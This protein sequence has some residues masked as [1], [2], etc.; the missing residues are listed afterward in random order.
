VV[1]CAKSAARHGLGGAPGAAPGCAGWYIHCSK[2]RVQNATVVSSADHK[3]A[4]SADQNTPD[5]LGL[6]R[7]RLCDVSPTLS[8]ILMLVCVLA[9]HCTGRAEENNPQPTVTLSDANST[10]A[11]VTAIAVPTA[12]T[13][14]LSLSFQFSPAFTNMAQANTNR[15]IATDVALTVEEFVLEKKSPESLFSEQPGTGHLGF[16]NFQ[17]GYGQAF[18]SDSILLRGRNGTAWEETRYLFVKTVVRF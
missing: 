12:G 14:V 17:A 4:S 2:G 3:A 18:G 7:A 16:A 15:S 9:G 8:S 11:I 1:R 5:V 10:N 6:L 13:N